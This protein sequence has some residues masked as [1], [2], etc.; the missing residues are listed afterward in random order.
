M[1]EIL[2]VGVDAHRHGSVG[3]GSLPGIMP[4]I[5]MTKSL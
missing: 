2:H 5:A 4:G 1:E 3:K